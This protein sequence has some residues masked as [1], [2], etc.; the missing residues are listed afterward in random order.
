MMVFKNSRDSRPFSDRLNRLTA[1]PDQSAAADVSGA[2]E[3]H[4]AACGQWQIGL[5]FDCVLTRLDRLDL[6]I[7]RSSNTVLE[8]FYKFGKYVI[9]VISNI[10]EPDYNPS[11]TVEVVI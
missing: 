7:Y 11:D 3:S 10:V 4:E 9:S 5:G 1:R 6:A 8:L 2:Q